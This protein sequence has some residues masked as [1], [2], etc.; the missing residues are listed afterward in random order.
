MPD[1]HVRRDKAAHF[2]PVQS[3]PGNRSIV[4]MPCRMRPLRYTHQRHVGRG[5]RTSCSGPGCRPAWLFVG[6]RVA[7]ALTELGLIDEYEFVV[8]PRLA[9][10]GPTLLATQ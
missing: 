7:R 9:G 4:A 8:Q 5:L 3:P 10:H 6:V 2:Q 1:N